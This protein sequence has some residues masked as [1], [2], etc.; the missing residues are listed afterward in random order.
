M[1]FDPVKPRYSL[2]FNKTTYELEGSFALI[3]A[4][5]FALKDSFLK[6]AVR[7]VNGMP[8]SEF[9]KLLSTILRG[10]GVKLTAEQI[11]EILWNDLGVGSDEYAALTLHVFAFMKICIAKPTDR[12]EVTRKMG[13]LLGKLSTPASPGA[14]TD[15]SA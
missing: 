13:E 14:G 1:S 12:M 8:V 6:I 11:G 4:V 15:A 2:P 5:E 10:T 3:E 9:A 7:A